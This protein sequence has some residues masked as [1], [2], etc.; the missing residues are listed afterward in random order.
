[1]HSFACLIIAIIFQ[2]I[3]HQYYYS[4]NICRPEVLLKIGGSFVEIAAQEK[5]V[6]GY[7]ELVK[8][9][10]LDENV[11]TEALEKCVSYFNTLFPIILGADVKINHTRSLSDNVKCL[12]SA[13]DGI[14]NDALVIRN[15]IEV[16]TKSSIIEMGCNVNVGIK[17]Y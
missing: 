9:D 15:L 13:C 11:P 17:Y 8:R 4:L 2:T 3:L 10:Q 6:D 14:I 16:K 7:V 1:M 5:I 12:Y